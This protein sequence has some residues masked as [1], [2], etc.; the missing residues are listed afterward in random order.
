MNAPKADT[1]PEKTMVEVWDVARSFGLDPFPTHF[2][3]VPAAMNV[4]VF[5]RVVPNQ[6]VDDRLRLLRR[7]R[8]VEV[9]ERL[10]ADL[11]RQN[12]EVAANARDVERVVLVNDR[13]HRS[14]SLRSG[15]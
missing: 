6:P 1:D 4:R 13:A 11:A 15:R 5:F 10:A 2:E 14:F 12:R 9:D 8:V 7:R 3:V